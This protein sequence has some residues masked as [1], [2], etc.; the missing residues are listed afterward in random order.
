MRIIIDIE[1]NG[2]GRGGQEAP[3]QRRRTLDERDDMPCPHRDDGH[4]PES[5]ATRKL[6]ELMF[7]DPG[8]PGIPAPYR[9]PRDVIIRGNIPAGTTIVPPPPFG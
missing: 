5:C 8:G 2:Y 9:G 7:P 1:E 4:Q 6:R 3:R